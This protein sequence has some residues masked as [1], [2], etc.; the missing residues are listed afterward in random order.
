LHLCGCYAP[1]APPSTKNRPCRAPMPLTAVRPSV[2]I[3]G[4]AHHAHTLLSTYST[5]PFEYGVVVTCEIRGDARGKQLALATGRDLSRRRPP[6]PPEDRRHQLRPGAT[7]CLQPRQARG[8]P[9]EHRQRAIRRR[10]RHS[11]PC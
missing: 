3:A 4:M 6:R 8:Y 2:L 11:L 7:P 10:T 1:P 9:D 5:P